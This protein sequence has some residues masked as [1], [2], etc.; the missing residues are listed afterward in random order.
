MIKVFSTIDS[1]DVYFAQV[2]ASFFGGYCYLARRKG[3][4][5]FWGVMSK[6]PMTND[7]I[8]QAI[9]DY[10]NQIHGGQ[11]TADQIRLG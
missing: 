10:N 1:Q 9:L 5:Q 3:Y 6:E 2:T 4:F 11:I 8:V 7:Q